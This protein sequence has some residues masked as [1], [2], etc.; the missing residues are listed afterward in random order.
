[1]LNAEILSFNEVI[2]KT[3]LVSQMWL[4]EILILSTAIIIIIILIF[5]II[6]LIQI[7]L[8][9]NKWIKDA[10]NRKKL[11]HK[12]ITQKEIENEIEEEIKKL[13][14]KE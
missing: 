8:R 9:V 13:N 5:Y 14:L 7:K 6:P 12:I 1:M 10:Q 2:N 11:L 4:L 3:T